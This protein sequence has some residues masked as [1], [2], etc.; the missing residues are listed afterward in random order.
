MNV[1]YPHTIENGQ[2]ETLTFSRVQVEPDGDKLLVD[3]VVAPGFGPPM[4]VHWQ[5]DESLT[6]VRGRIGYQ[7]QG[8]AEQ[9]ADAGATVLF[10]RGVA[11]RFWNAGAEPLRCTGWNK[12][13]NSIVFY[14]SSVY[15]AQVKSGKLQP[16]TFD[17][18]YLLTR[19]ASE[20]DMLE[21]PRFVRKVI[22]PATYR[23]GRLLRKYKHFED[24]PKPLEAQ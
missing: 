16:E 19:Y 9:F 23:L 17:A 20:Y 13:A 4:H 18:A 3:N 5:Q 6:V 10:E 24:A 1:T 15:A 12:P 21:I 14:L 7:I 11:H 2:G 8:Q 22:L